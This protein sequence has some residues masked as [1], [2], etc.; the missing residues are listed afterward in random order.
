MNTWYVIQTKPHK[1][2]V[3]A[4]LLRKAGFEIFFPK[5]KS[6]KKGTAPLF[7]LYIFV[8]ADLENVFNH[9][10]VKFTRG[11]NRI[12]GTEG[13]PRPISCEAIEMINERVNSDKV[14]EYDQLKAGR[15][16]K[17]TRGPFQDL[18]GILEKPVTAAGRVAVLLNVFGRSVRMF[19]HA[20]DIAV[21]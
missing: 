16:I 7:P 12:L 4:T 5:V 18:L 21:A 17:I 13:K 14:L 19:A 11:V 3:A 10:L 8:N 9:R 15:E 2:A 20:K 1:E 6:V